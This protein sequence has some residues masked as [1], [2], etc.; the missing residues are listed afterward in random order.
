MMIPICFVICLSNDDRKRVVGIINC[1]TLMVLVICN[2][3]ISN[4]IVEEMKLRYNATYSLTLRV[5]DDIYESDGFSSGS[6]VAI[7]G[8]VFTQEWENYNKGLLDRCDKDVASWGQVWASEANT[9]QYLYERYYNIYHGIVL[10]MATDE[11]VDFIIDTDEF[12]DMKCYPNDGSIK[13][14]NNI[15]VVKLSNFDD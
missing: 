3:M 9:N 13:K 6:R 8:N 1:F 5:L 14:I 2:I 7:L 10:N 4:G 12:K 11:E 15:T